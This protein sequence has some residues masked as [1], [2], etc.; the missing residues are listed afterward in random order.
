MALPTSPIDAAKTIFAGLSIIEFTPTGGAKLTFE[1]RMLDQSLDQEQ[2][3]LEQPDSAGVVRR[4]RS[5][6]TKRE[7][8]FKFELPEVK[9]LLDLFGGK[10]AGS[11][12]GVCTLWLP[13]PSDAAGKVALKSEVGFACTVTRDGNLKF[14]DNDF[15]KATIS[16][17]SNKKGDIS[18]TADVVA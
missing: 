2:K 17:I 8:S 7:E 14:G 15:S 16:I 6:A 13:D 11:I 12:A 3:H 18:W 5:V 10:L 9:R 1:S 4:I